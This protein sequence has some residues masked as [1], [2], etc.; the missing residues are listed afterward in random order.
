MN[1]THSH[2]TVRGLAALVL[3]AAALGAQSQPTAPYL[4]GSVGD[5]DFGT[6]LRLFGGA[7]ISNIIGWEAQLTSFGSRRISPGGNVSCSNSAWALGAG[8]TATM[9]LTSAVSAF[10]KLGGHYLKTRVGGPCSDS[11]D[12]SLEL[13]LGAGVLWQFSPKAALRVEFENIGGSGGDFI[14]VGVQFPL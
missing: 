13:G 10:G 4:G 9:P 8:A 12:G 2:S 6:G 3:S 14:S 1:R 7:R 11:G 5:T